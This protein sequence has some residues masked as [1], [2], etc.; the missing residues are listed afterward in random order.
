MDSF[1]DATQHTRSYQIDAFPI[2]LWKQ[3]ITRDQACL[4]QTS[5]YSSQSIEAKMGAASLCSPYEQSRSRCYH[6]G[7]ERD[8]DHIFLACNGKRHIAGRWCWSKHLRHRLRR[9]I[10]MMIIVDY[11]VPWTRRSLENRGMYPIFRAL[12]EPD[13]WRLLELKLKKHDHC[14]WTYTRVIGTNRYRRVESSR[15]HHFVDF[16]TIHFDVIVRTG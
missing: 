8:K 15:W 11:T 3:R 14:R 4:K 12:P 2:R 10:M 7:E 13:D 5:T 1:G 6:W 9:R 16:S